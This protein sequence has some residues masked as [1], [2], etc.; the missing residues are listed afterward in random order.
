M[1]S[2]VEPSLLE[3]LAGPKCHAPLREDVEGPYSA[4]TLAKELGPRLKPIAVDK[5]ASCGCTPPGRSI[6][7]SLSST[8]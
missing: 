4:A 5:G 3:I 8:C 7:C 1:A 2:L 6:P